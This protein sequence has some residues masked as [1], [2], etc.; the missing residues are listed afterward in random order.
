MKSPNRISTFVAAIWLLSAAVA[1]AQI[2]VPDIQLPPPAPPL[3]PVVTPLPP[4]PPLPPPPPP[5]QPCGPA[6]CI[7][8]VP[9]P[10]AVQNNNNSCLPQAAI[11]Q[12]APA[13]QAARPATAQ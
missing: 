11:P 5:P 1:Q 8:P 6:G 10:C 9:A 3:P 2:R 7:R 4:L 12:A 13:A